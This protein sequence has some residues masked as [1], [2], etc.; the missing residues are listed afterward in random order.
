MKT[1]IFFIILIS[2]FAVFI[3]NSLGSTFGNKVKTTSLLKAYS[4]AG[5]DVVNINTQELL[6]LSSTTE[7]K[8]ANQKASESA[9]KLL[10]ISL[11][12]QAIA[13]LTI[14]AFSTFLIYRGCHG[15]TGSRQAT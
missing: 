12:A 7:A 4:E 3:V 5:I 6:A 13:I 1:K 9:G 10:A 15:R 8:I 2:Y 14:A 11:A